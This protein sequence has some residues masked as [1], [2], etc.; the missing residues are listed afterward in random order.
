MEDV[1]LQ[2]VSGGPGAKAVVLRWRPNLL[3]EGGLAWGTLVR[4]AGRCLASAAALEGDAAGEAQAALHECVK[5]IASCE[6]DAA[7]EAARA[8]AAAAEGR[9]P[10][11]G[12]A[13]RDAAVL[14]RAAEALADTRGE[15][16]AIVDVVVLAGGPAWR[17]ALDAEARRRGLLPPR[18][19]GTPPGG[20]AASRPAAPPAD[21]G[22]GN[23]VVELH[24]PHPEAAEFA[25]RHMREPGEPAVL[26]GA[27]AHWPA[28]ERWVDAAHLRRVGGGRA[29]PVEVGRHYLA[30]GWR[31]EVM[32]L[33]DFIERH[34]DPGGAGGGPV[35]Y[36][37]QHALFDQV[38]E[39]A[40]DID[41][42]AY[43]LSEATAPDGGLKSTN[44]WF[45]PAGTVTPLHFD[46]DH[47]LLAQ[48][49]GRKLVRLYAPSESASLHPV[50]DDPARANAA[51]V[52]VDRPDH[53]AFP[54]FATA[55]FQE[56]TL[57]PG[58]ALY[59]PPGW[60]HYVRALDVSFSVSFWWR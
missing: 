15:D 49:V 5:R 16:S 54:L 44:A 7:A 1:V 30:D 28:L 43:C 47:N 22:R 31:Q 50:E 17:A 8:A 33:G 37:A 48:A 3:M 4:F 45:G 32:A 19:D 55:P 20:S 27:V 29:V 34:V 24:A 59:I 56:V 39:L 23:A 46:P 13:W 21:E 53:A 36:L 41:V 57:H 42:P 52:D 11:G 40:G 2:V 25:A 6:L 18:G 26:R 35:A 12:E 58:D 38:P 51:R 14:A 10:G 9:L 60:W